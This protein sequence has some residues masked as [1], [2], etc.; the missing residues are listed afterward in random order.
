MPIK[1]KVIISGDPNLYQMLS[2]Y[3]EDFWEIFKVKADFDSEIE[4][5]K[6]NV[7][8]Y[9]A[10]LS[11]CCDE[12]ETRHFDPSGVARV[13]EYS[14]RV[15]GDQGKLSS[16]FAQVK[17]W[18]EEADYWAAR[19]NAKYISAHHV[20]KAIDERY[21]RHNLTD[22]K[23]KDA[24]ERGT[25]MIDTDGE[26]TGQVNALSVYSLGDITFGKPSKITART[27]LGRG[28][29]INIEREAQ[30]SGPTHNKG[31]MILSGYLGWKYAQDKPLSLSASIC[32]EQSY[33]GVDGDSA[34]STEL[35]AILS[36]V[37]GIPIKQHI[38][39]TG[40]VNQAG[41]IQPIGG[42]NQ[43]IEG[44]FQIC[45]ARGLTGM[46]GVMIPEQNLRNLM[47]SDNIVEA[48]KK[49]TFHIYSAKTIDEGIEILTGVRAGNKKK[50]GS[51][52]KGTVNY[53][54]D[55][56]LREMAEKLRVFGSDDRKGNKSGKGTTGK[57]VKK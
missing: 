21:F 20:Q 19:D 36:S 38:A 48:V 44:F 12:C 42:V 32:F 5:T 49:G 26:K 47:L 10:F 1:V 13:I 55:T 11:G 54:V 27:F 8:A 9:A 33:G 17:E 29:I 14:A 40:S 45:Q 51:Y 28:G 35:Y 2:M 41:E 6:E 31:V 16:R 15:V 46:Q 34:S 3:D 24:I 4:N 50:D 18:I 57:Q 7:L 56:A 30:L 22:E 43:K 53:L 52:P 23:L 39:V 37:A 25:I